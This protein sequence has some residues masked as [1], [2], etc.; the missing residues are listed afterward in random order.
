MLLFF[1]RIV[2]YISDDYSLRRIVYTYVARILIYVD[3]IIGYQ[4]LVNS[5]AGNYYRSYNFRVSL[6]MYIMST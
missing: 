4:T 1:L 3:E 2:S 6:P 5:H